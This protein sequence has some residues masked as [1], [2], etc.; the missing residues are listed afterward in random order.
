MVGK[1]KKLLKAFNYN[2]T[3]HK[4]NLNV[5][6]FCRNKNEIGAGLFL[7]KATVLAWRYQVEHIACVGALSVILAML[8]AKNHCQMNYQICDGT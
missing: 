6:S 3:K 1:N 2:Q 8:G 7:K 4:S 5:S